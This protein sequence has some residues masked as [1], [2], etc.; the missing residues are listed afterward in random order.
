MKESLATDG[1]TCATCGLQLAHIDMACPNCLPN[2]Y[3]K[4]ASACPSCA[5]RFDPALGHECSDP[6]CTDC[7]K[8]GDEA[9]WNPRSERWC[10]CDRGIRA[11]K[12]A[13][14]E[15]SA[16]Q[17]RPLSSN[18][19]LVRRLRAVQLIWHD[20]SRQGCEAA[21]RLGAL[22]AEAADEIERLRK[23]LSVN[24]TTVSYKCHECGAWHLRVVE[25]AADRPPAETDAGFSAWATDPRTVALMK[26][27]G[28]TSVHPEACDYLQR[29]FFEIHGLKYSIEDARIV[30]ETAMRQQVKV[31]NESLD[32]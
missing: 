3:Q 15:I 22:I 2:F 29:Y 26:R 19:D 31:G 25:A 28:E 20:G 17:N 7:I 13:I 32:K 24:D 12:R 18:L 27:C 1:V 5:E 8:D 21:A 23:L 10:E 4:Q 30:L 9:G 16:E 11:R 14:A 6:D